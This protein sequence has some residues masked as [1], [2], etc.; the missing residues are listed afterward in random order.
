MKQQFKSISKIHV[1][2]RGKRV[3]LQSMKTQGGRNLKNINDN[4]STTHIITFLLGAH[5]HSTP[6]T[7]LWQFIQ[8]TVHP[9]I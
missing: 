3:L 8:V 4:D 5:S 9:I 6:S 7:C 1:E 2:I